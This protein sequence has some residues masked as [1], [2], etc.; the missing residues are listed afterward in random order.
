MYFRCV[1]SIECIQGIW[2]AILSANL[3]HKVWQSVIE[4]LLCHLINNYGTR[5]I[6]WVNT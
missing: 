3:H 4:F 2:L 1:L 5:G 6:F